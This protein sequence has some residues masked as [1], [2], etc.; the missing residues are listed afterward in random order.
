MIQIRRGVF[1]TNSSSTHSICICT[2]EKYKN[3]RSPSG[4]YYLVNSWGGFEEFLPNK[5][6]GIISKENLQKAINEY[7]K[8]YEDEHKNSKWYEP[9]DIHMLEHSDDWDVEN[10]RHD[11]R[12]DL[13]IFS[14]GDWDRHNDEL[15]QYAKHFTTPSG[16]KMVAFGSYGYN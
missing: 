6:N 3:W 10:K 8:L 13:G 9:V 2:E 4:E 14:L 5:E 1:E 11:T 15:E 7:A 16:D 12:I